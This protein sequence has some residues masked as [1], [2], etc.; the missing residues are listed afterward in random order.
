MTNDMNLRLNLDLL[1][2][3]RELALLRSARYK[4]QTEK[5]YNNKVKHIHLKIGDFVLRRN[6]ASRQEGQKKLDPNWE[7]PYQVTDIKRTGT[8]A[9]ADMIGRSIP[10]TCHIS[11]VRNFRF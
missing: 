5:Y 7:G 11:N 1:E 9:L 6:E 4:I 8:Y 3:R 10:L 2:E